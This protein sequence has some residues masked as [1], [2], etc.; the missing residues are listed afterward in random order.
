MRRRFAFLIATTMLVVTLPPSVGLLAPGLAAGKCSPAKVA[1]PKWMPKSLP[2]PKGTYTT[3]RM[4]PVGG[5]KQARFVLPF[6]TRRFARFVLRK[7]PKRGWEL[8]RG[9]SEA[10]QVESD[11]S[12]APAVG[13]FRA[14]DLRC[15]TV[16]WLILDRDGPD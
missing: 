8:G 9:D 12:K 4:R 3:R 5:Y 6:G 14:D 11:F 15:K 13:G 10:T 1:W 7:W 16:L 2:L